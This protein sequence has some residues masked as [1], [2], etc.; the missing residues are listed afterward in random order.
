MYFELF[1]LAMLVAIN[2][3]KYMHKSNKKNSK[4]NYQHNL[5]NIKQILWSIQKCII[6]QLIVFVIFIRNRKKKKHYIQIY[7]NTFF[8]RIPKS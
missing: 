2:K 5:L 7:I 6:D 8:Y 4:I 3:P 1:S